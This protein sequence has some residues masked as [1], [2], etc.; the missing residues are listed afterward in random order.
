MSI[1]NTNEFQ[2]KI[3]SRCR[4][5]KNSY[6]MDS[7]ICT[8]CVDAHFN[9]SDAHINDAL[10]VTPQVIHS[11]PHLPS[12]EI[13]NVAA[14][15]SRLLQKEK[16]TTVIKTA[17]VEEI[18]MTNKDKNYGESPESRVQ[19]GEKLK[20]FRTKLGLTA[21][22]AAELLKLKNAPAVVNA[23]VGCSSKIFNERFALYKQLELD[24]KNQKEALPGALNQTKQRGRPA[25]VAASAVKTKPLT[26]VTTTKTPIAS[27]EREKQERLAAQ[28]AKVEAQR[29]NA[30]ARSSSAQSDFERLKQQLVQLEALLAKSVQ[31]TAAAERCSEV[32]VW[33]S[34]FGDQAHA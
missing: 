23:E 29:N 13:S 20:N 9:Q 4:L 17:P 24:L 19:N 27:L 8:R 21:K 30:A 34:L 32:M 26:S 18:T 3:C 2:Q 6:F 7:N 15:Y 28:E 5:P 25:G 16:T 10:N 11:E 31:R 22:R 12:T 33:A 14:A 1:Q